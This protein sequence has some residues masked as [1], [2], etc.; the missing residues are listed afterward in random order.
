MVE[1]GQVG[2]ARYLAPLPRLEGAGPEFP[3]YPL[4]DRRIF[5]NFQPPPDDRP[6]FT[7]EA[8]DRANALLLSVLPRGERESFLADGQFDFYG[9]QGGHWRFRAR[10]LDCYGEPWLERCLFQR[11]RQCAKDYLHPMFWVCLYLRPRV[12]PG[13]GMAAKYLLVRSDEGRVLRAMSTHQRQ[14]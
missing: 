10:D 5:L 3:L 12:P 6:V 1:V 11:H 13:D 8:Q 4:L 14:V 9:S 7:A 2:Q